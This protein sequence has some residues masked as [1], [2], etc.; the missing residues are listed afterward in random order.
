[1]PRTQIT[2]KKGN[3]FSHLNLIYF[4]THFAKGSAIS[5]E[6]LSLA[7]IVTDSI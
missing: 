3:K 5:E 7:Y 1:M 6:E 4:Q 2:L